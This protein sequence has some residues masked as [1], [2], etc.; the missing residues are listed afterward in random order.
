MRDRRPAPA[1]KPPMSSMPPT[2]LETQQMA[3]DGNRLAEDLWTLADDIGNAK[4][5]W[6]S[7][8]TTEELAAADLLTTAFLRLGG[9]A[10]RGEIA[11]GRG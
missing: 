4:L 3:Q 11:Y 1:S 9:Q 5:A 7:R 2:S 10:K 8:F 6:R